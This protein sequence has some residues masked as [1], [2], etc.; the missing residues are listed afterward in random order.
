VTEGSRP[1]PA[2]SEVVGTAQVSIEVNGSRRRL[3]VDTR[4]RLIEVLRDDFELSSVR[5]GCSVGM[6][7][8]CTVLVDGAAVSSCL[9]LAALCDGASVLTAE[10]L[11]AVDGL[12]RIARAFVE[13]RAFQCGYCT[14]GFV[15]GLCGLLGAEPSPSRSQLESWLSGHLCRC[16]SYSRILEAAATAVGAT[17]VA[18]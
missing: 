12:D 11:G 3:R 13:A 15:M 18:R 1:A 17:G 6:C 14:P 16:G 2:D 9:T 10:A 5:D 7:G 8:A 4:T